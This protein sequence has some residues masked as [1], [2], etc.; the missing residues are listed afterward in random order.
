M[1]IEIAVLLN[2]DGETSSFNESGVIKVF[3]KQE[4]EWNKTK[5]VLFNVEENINIIYF[6][7]NILSIV[8]SL[9]NCKV[10]VARYISGIAYNIL[11]TMGFSSWEIHGVPEKFLDCL[12]EDE[13]LYKANKV[14]TEKSSN[15]LSTPVQTSDEGFYYMNLK[16]LQSS[17]SNLSTK[18][19][20]LPFLKN[21]VFYELEL[22]CSHIPPWF[23]SEFK[24]MNL[25][26]DI[27][28]LGQNDYKIKIYHKECTIN[29]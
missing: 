21:T 24:K 23:E 18:Q 22:L 9:G 8:N 19:V 16:E 10:F 26:T 27:H 5:E 11:D 20:L 3:S 4:S 29:P 25:T 28:E 7:E 14:S 17:N 1:C 6:R 13:K 12:L 15:T 2:S